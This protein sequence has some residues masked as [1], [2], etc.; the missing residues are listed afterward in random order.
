MTT[1]IVRAGA[2]AFL[3]FLLPPAARTQQNE[4]PGVVRETAGVTVIVPAESFQCWNGFQPG[5][6]MPTLTVCAPR[7]SLAATF[8]LAVKV[9]LTFRVNDWLSQYCWNTLPVEL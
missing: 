7:I 6:N 1:R 3:V 4:R 8:Q 2:A 9:R 5:P